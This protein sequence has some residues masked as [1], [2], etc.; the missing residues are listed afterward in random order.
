MNAEQL[1]AL[2]VRVEAFDQKLQRI[3]ENKNL[4]PS[5]QAAAI[6]LLTSLNLPLFAKVAAALRARAAS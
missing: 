2:A 6:A 5:G 4:S 3:A 1:E